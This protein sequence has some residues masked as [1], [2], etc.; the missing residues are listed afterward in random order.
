MLKWVKKLGQVIKPAAAIV[1]PLVSPTYKV[2]AAA[3][4]VGSVSGT[5]VACGTVIIA[6]A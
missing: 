4:T 6:C 5:T 1:S 3:E 2:G